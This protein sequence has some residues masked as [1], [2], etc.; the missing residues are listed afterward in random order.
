[1][2]DVNATLRYMHG[3]VKELTN[4]FTGMPPDKILFV[5]RIK[6]SHINAI[7]KLFT[8]VINTTID[9][10]KGGLCS[11]PKTHFA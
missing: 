3:L 8:K 7:E 9:R 2:A 10:Y 11:L 6:L 1:M 4:Q 5:I